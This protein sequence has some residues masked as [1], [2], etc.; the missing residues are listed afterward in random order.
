MNIVFFAKKEN[1][2]LYL[3]SA[4]PIVRMKQAIKP[5]ILNFLSGNISTCISITIRIDKLMT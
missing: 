2:T 3:T 5:F 1:L 4:Q